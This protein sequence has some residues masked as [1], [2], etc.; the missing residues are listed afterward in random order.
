M[1]KPV[2]GFHDINTLLKNV[3]QYFFYTLKNSTKNLARL[4]KKKNQWKLLANVGTL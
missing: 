2:H 3:L 4:K 1:T